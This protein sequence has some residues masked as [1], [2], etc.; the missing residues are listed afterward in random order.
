MRVVS[1][2]S[3]LSNLAIIDRLELLH[4]Q[5]GR[6][7][8]PLAVQQE[9]KR[10]RKP[11]AIKRLDVGFEQGWLERLKLVP[12]ISTE[13]SEGIHAGEAAAIACAK[14]LGADRV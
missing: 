14:E 2:T 4:E 8:V 1:N 11:E 9:L 7:L 10:L 3:P 13:V 6:V 5:F 12:V